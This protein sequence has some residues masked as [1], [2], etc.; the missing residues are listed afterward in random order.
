VSFVEIKHQ[1]FNRNF[2]NATQRA[3]FKN[4]GAKKLANPSK[5]EENEEK[6]NEIND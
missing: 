3:F 6:Y 1:A 4:L 5:N 2:Q